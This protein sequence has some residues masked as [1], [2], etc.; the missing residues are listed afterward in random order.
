MFKLSKAQFFRNMIQIIVLVWLL[1]A[2][3]INLFR[4]D[5]TF[6]MFY[7]FGKG[8]SFSEAM[9]FF[10]AFM[11]MAALL[12]ILAVFLGRILCGWVCPYNTTQEFFS[13]VF[14]M[15]PQKPWKVVFYYFLVFVVSLVAATSLEAYFIHPKYLLY[16]LKAGQFRM[17]TI[18]LF[19]LFVG[20]LLLFLRMR[21][22]FCKGYC[23]Y[24]AFQM[25]LSRKPV[26]VVFD[27]DHQDDCLDCEMCQNVCHMGIDPRDMDIEY[28]VACGKCIDGCKSI[29]SSNHLSHLLSYKKITHDEYERRK[30]EY[31]KN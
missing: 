26:R 18:L 1:V 11:G 9:L 25:V 8:Y 24:A 12:F 31:F 23:P 19:S 28:C 2:P 20:F 7:L 16:L 10:Y 13:R 27:V 14:L 6:R 21:H 5:I 29:V 17:E 4:L 22:Q 3:Y 15:K 30:K